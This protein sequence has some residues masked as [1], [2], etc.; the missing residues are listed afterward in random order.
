MKHS[1]FSVAPTVNENNEE[2]TFYR[3][4]GFKLVSIMGLVSV[5]LLISVGVAVNEFGGDNEPSKS[6]TPDNDLRNLDKATAIGAEANGQG[7]HDIGFGQFATSKHISE[8]FNL[9]ACLRGTKLEPFY[10]SLCSI[11][12]RHRTAIIA[13]AIFSIML[14]AA[15]GIALAV[16]CENERIA[17]ELELELERQ[18]E[19]E[20]QQALLASQF[21][22]LVTDKGWKWTAIVKLVLGAYGASLIFTALMII[23]DY[24]HDWGVFFPD[25]RTGRTIIYFLNFITLHSIL[26]GIF[27]MLIE[28]ELF[29]LKILSFTRVKSFARLI[30]L[31]VIAILNIVSMIISVPMSIMAGLMYLAGSR[32]IVIETYG[33]IWFSLWAEFQSR[34]SEHLI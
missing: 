34:F 22:I 33:F 2:L 8:L 25:N 20:R 29:L 23:V 4:S 30:F 3:K 7:L 28:L 16:H 9:P 13:G 15:A 27:T 6:A 18:R 12:A 11:W 1:T 24:L 32:N 19:L 31:I 17:K 10:M 14:A 21:D 26:A 5:L